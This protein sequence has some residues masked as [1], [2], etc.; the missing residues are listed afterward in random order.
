MDP[1]QGPSFKTLNETHTECGQLQKTPFDVYIEQVEDPVDKYLLLP[2]EEETKPDPELKL[3][4][5][6]PG[7]LDDY[8]LNHPI[9]ISTTTEVAEIGTKQKLKDTSSYEGRIK[10]IKIG[11]T[12][13][14]VST[15]FQYNVFCY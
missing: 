10:E 8:L 6:T 9:N 3:M 5:A 12:W 14:L 15:N 13:K 1:A 4:P 2:S 11:L 7:T